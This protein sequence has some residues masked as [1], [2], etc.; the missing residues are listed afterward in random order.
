MDVLEEA[1][2]RR[3]D[4]RLLV[5]LLIPAASVSLFADTTGRIG[6]VVVD[7]AGKPVPGAK[8]TLKRTDRNWSKEIIADAKGAIFQV[9]LDPVEY[10]MTVSAPGFQDLKGKDKI[11]LGDTL[12]KTFTLYKPGEAPAGTPGAPAPE[13]PVADPALKLDAESRDAFNAALPLYNE[14][15]YAEALAP[16]EKAYKGMTEAMATVKDETAKKE[17]ETILPS[18]EKAYGNTLFQV[19]K[20]EEALPLLLKVVERDPKNLSALSSLVNIYQGKKDKENEKKY[21]AMVDEIA[22]P[23]PENAYNAGVEAFNAGKMREAKANIMKAIEVDP[24]FADSYYML[25]LIEANANNLGACKAAL[26]KYLEL[27]PSG[28]KAGE[29]REMLKSL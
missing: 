23:R 19:G 13:A 7:K 12:K 25:G 3:I 8:L 5:G 27:A 6:G 29:V 26:R 4:P 14:K 28:K 21:Q 15:K 10:E 20:K 2:M 24:K 18:V 16:F 11:P 9:G 17:I 1:S 22:G